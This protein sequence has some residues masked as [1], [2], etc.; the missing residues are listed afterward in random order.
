MTGPSLR[1]SPPPAWHPLRRRLAV[2]AVFSAA[3][4]LWLLSGF[5]TVSPDELG[6]VTRFGRLRDS[7]IMPGLHY[8]WP[9]PIERVYTPRTTG[10]KQLQV[11][12]TTL[13]LPSPERRSSDTLTGDENIL[14]IMMVV[15]YKVLDPMAYLFKT[16]DA[17]GL[18]ER[19]VQFAVSRQVAAL[20]VDDVL[21]TAKDEIQV[22]AIA[23][24]Q[25]LLD[26]YEA[27]IVLLG[28]SLQVVDPPVPVLA[29]FKEVAS[30]KKDSERLLDE[31][32]EYESKVLPEARGQADRI[33]SDARGFHADRVGRA[34]GDAG[35]FL[36]IL[37]EYRR[38]R[39]VTRTRLYV[40]TMERVF[41]KMNVIVLDRADGPGASKVTIVDR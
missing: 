28:G 1:S 15:Q 14:K 16:E 6:V 31:A 40:E 36:S 34:R 8:A 12:F 3:V 17:H 2:L 38:A 4:L 35:R 32:R 22:R 37:T 10:V 33:I 41:A 21:T 24:A 19:A 25:G 11:G 9:R 39:D 29:A 27:G 30:A 23:L 7:R 5:Y 13:G 18:V 20:P 26:A